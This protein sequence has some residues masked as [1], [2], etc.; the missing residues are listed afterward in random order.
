[1]LALRELQDQ[2]PFLVHLLSI[3]DLNARLR[4]HHPEIVYRPGNRFRKTVC[5]P[6][7]PG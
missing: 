4:R 2:L 1:M 5:Y 7:L 3:P 6:L